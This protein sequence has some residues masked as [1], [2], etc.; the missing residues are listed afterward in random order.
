MPNTAIRPIDL[1]DEAHAEPQP[2]RQLGLIREAAVD[3][4]RWFATTGKP[5][6][7]G[8]FD[9]A[10]VPYPTRF[11]LLH[12]GK[13]LAP[14]VTMVNRLVVVRWQ[15]GAG[16]LRTLLWEPSDVDL[17]RNCP[18]Y[19]N[20]AAKTPTF[21]EPLGF[22]KLGT[23]EGHL[24]S[25][26]I[27]LDEVDY[28][29]FDHMHIQDVRRLL[30]TTGPARDLGSEGP[31]PP[32][33]PRAKLIV[34]R[35][36]LEMLRALHPLQRAW[37]QPETFTDIPQDRYRVVEG[38]VL[39]G[40]GVALLHTPGHT[41]GNH[42]LVL[43]TDTGIWASSENVIAAEC[44]TPEHSR[45]RGLRRWARDM[46]QEVILNGNTIETTAQQYNSVIKEK[47]I[48]DRCAKNPDILQFQPTAELWPNWVNVGAQ[49]T[50]THG[51]I[52]HGSLL[53]GSVA[54]S[55]A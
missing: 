24:T 1:F 42:S 3:F 47:C 27:G 2:G 50:F 33:F 31:V 51:G 46:D 26:G 17:G 30:G 6:Y 32:L 44:L 28:L 4:R 36:E 11:G 5:L 9:L 45:I 53:A 52:R 23:V 7:V 55:P 14:F 8:S 25:L 15:D 37:Y 54:S 22:R 38:D 39:L 40:P 18:F 49:P 43:H 20:L 12:A 21:L 10:A 41:P 35:A 29:S 13:A 19:K 48:V 34:Q 16:R